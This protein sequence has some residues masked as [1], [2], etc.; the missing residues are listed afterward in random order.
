M[1]YESYER[2]ILRIKKIRDTILKYK[3]LIMA[4]VIAITATV[5]GLLGVKGVFT[6]GIE[7]EASY[8]YGEE[9][10]F[11]ANA[12]LADVRYEY[13][14]LGGEWTPFSPDMPGEY[15][16]RAVAKRGFGGENY[17]DS[18]S[19]TIVPKVA[20]IK[21]LDSDI[22]YGEN[23]SIGVSGLVKKDVLDTK[24]LAFDFM[25]VTSASPKAAIDVATFKIVDA[26]GKDRTRAYDFGDRLYETI[27]L[28]LQKRDLEISFGSAE[29]YYDGTTLACEEWSCTGGSFALA[30]KAEFT[31]FSDRVEVGTVDNV[32][33]MTVTNDKGIDVTSLYNLTVIEGSLQVKRRPLS[34]STDSAEKIYDGNTLEH[35]KFKTE[36]VVEGIG[37]LDGHYLAI[38]ESTQITDVGS[39]ENVLSFAI[40]NRDGA[41]MANCYQLTTTYGLLTIDPRPI[42]IQPAEGKKL[43]SGKAYTSALASVTS[44]YKLADGEAL[45]DVEV[46]TRDLE[47]NDVK[48]ID[49]GEYSGYIASY[50]IKNTSTGEDKTANYLVTTTA[51]TVTI[52]P[53]SILVQM[54]DLEKEYDGLSVQKNQVA[55]TLV[56]VT[57][58][59]QTALAD[60]QNESILS[61]SPR[62][63]AGYYPD[64]NTIE[65]DILD[66]NGISVKHNYIIDVQAADLTIN[67]REVHLEITNQ[68]PIYNAKAHTSS[69]Y[70]ITYN[71]FALEHAPLL[72]LHTETLLG[73]RVDAIEVG[74]YINVL[75]SWKVFE[76]KNLTSDI[77]DNYDLHITNGYIWVQKRKIEVVISDQKKEYD[78]QPF[79]ASA[80]EYECKPNQFSL[81]EAIVGGQ[82]ATL[83]PLP[84]GEYVD[85]ATYSDVLQGTLE[86]KAGEDDK[87]HNYEISYV[88]GDVTITK[89]AVHIQ[90]ELISKIYDGIPVAPVEGTTYTVSTVHSFVDGHTETLTFWL[91]D[92]SGKR[93]EAV[94][95]GTY[96][97]G[98]DTISVV[99]ADG[100]IVTDNYE[101]TTKDNDLTI[102]YRPIKLTVTG[103]TKPYDA[104]PFDADE[105]VFAAAPKHPLAI[106]DVALPI[107]EAVALQL[108]T[109]VK[110][111][112]YKPTAKIFR[113]SKDTT[114]NY[115]IEYV[116]EQTL[117]ITK[118]DV[119]FNVTGKTVT[120]SGTEIGNIG[121]TVKDGSLALGDTA[122]IHVLTALGAR[123]IYVGDYTD[124]TAS[125]KN[126]KGE[127]VTNCY[128]LGENALDG[129]FTI[130]KRELTIQVEQ[131]LK[132]YDG[133][134]FKSESDVVFSYSALGQG[135]KIKIVITGVENC[136]DVGTYERESWGIA[137]SV[138][139]ASG[140]DV[141]GNYEINCLYSSGG[142][143]VILPRAVTIQPV[144]KTQPFNGR[145]FTSNACAA[146][147]G[148]TLVEGHVVEATTD[149]SISWIGMTNNNIVGDVVIRDA[150]G[151]DV[152]HNYTISKQS[153]VLE[154]IKREIYIIPLQL[155]RA[156]NGEILAY[157]ENF[158]ARERAY[159]R[160]R[161]EGNKKFGA[162]LY[163]GCYLMAEI[164]MSDFIVNVGTVD[165]SIISCTIYDAGGNDVTNLYY[166]V[167]WQTTTAK[168]TPKK[169][170]ISSRDIEKTYD[171]T[172]LYG[173]AE[174]CYISKG[175]LVGNDTIAYEVQ[176]SITDV[177]TVVNQIVSV[178]IKDETGT[179]RGKYV[180]DEY[181]NFMEGNDSYEYNY[182]IEIDCGSLTIVESL[183]KEANGG[184]AP[185]D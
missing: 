132:T 13:R 136:I 31:N 142:S 101:P 43:Y 60:A 126:A 50:K 84:Y 16:V 22:I 57:E 166:D 77:S 167:I 45:F 137:A 87:T 72:T 73:E 90:V 17:S 115:K 19:F 65:L 99:S 11:D 98:V 33:D 114:S 37:L 58:G 21:I 95:V 109:Y 5:C 100:R 3:Y 97:C 106:S 179:I 91:E 145:I 141:S 133:V 10:Q 39:V 110:V 134:S 96:R 149:G 59:M 163:D 46:L 139:D 185:V 7:L 154:L 6:R 14:E 125:F 82:K 61:L 55:Y 128:N 150:E 131:M 116:Y 63:N 74:D 177:G 51:A 157:P 118:R 94:D 151:N 173:A 52:D 28:T 102:D 35:L 40:R 80:Y 23:P 172:T 53:R 69:E 88:N 161:N 49:V 4:I 107:G 25:D 93:V 86:V 159:A 27:P 89:R 48:A 108:S 121:W 68:E 123:A 47:G 117:K 79:V 155:T 113:E 83:I 176:S 124:F 42:T 119:A 175:S 32:A 18:A 44:E 92:A 158:T 76:N 129:I 135:D 156:Y 127:D 12:I 78:D 85:A 148:T 174:D 34:V 56:P 181:G 184:G 103:T 75:D 66:G 15:E 1:S 152:T 130:E 2:K 168:V 67:K 38:T 165:V 171:G 105:V 146:V 138:A 164:E 153:G 160:W 112:E 143:L 64:E 71:S 29:Q 169:L 122:T 147:S 140:T 62:I 20:A 81:T 104:Y 111:G 30:D 54:H 182:S 120:Y 8:V 180:C 183:D 24:T 9:L 41:D 162:A 144:N 26:Q 178:I 170:I 70:T 36:E